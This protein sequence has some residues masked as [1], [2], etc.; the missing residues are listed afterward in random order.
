MTGGRA[1]TQPSRPPAVGDDEGFEQMLTAALIAL[2]IALVAA[3]FGFGG[4]AAGAVSIARVLFGL[5]L[6]VFLVTLVL[7][8]FGVGVVAV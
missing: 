7:S 6:V 2:V 1:R 8:L 4:I 5:F 3:V